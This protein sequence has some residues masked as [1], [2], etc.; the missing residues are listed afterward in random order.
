MNIDSVKVLYDNH[1]TFLNVKSI[2]KRV[3][4]LMGYTP[5]LEVHPDMYV[6][7]FELM[8]NKMLSSGLAISKSDLLSKL[9]SIVGIMTRM[10]KDPDELR[11]KILELKTDQTKQLPDVQ[12]KHDARSWSDILNIL[13]NI[14][15][16]SLNQFAKILAVCYKHG[17]VLRLGEIFNTT[18]ST[19]GRP[20]SASNFLDL[21]NKEWTINEHKAA[22]RVGQR[23]FPV[24]QAFVDELKK[25]ITFPDYLLI[26]K[27][28]YTAYATPLLGMIGINDFTVNEARNSYEEWNWKQSGRTLKEKRFWSEKV[29]GH[30]E[31][32]ARQFYTAHDMEANIMKSGEHPSVK[33]LEDTTGKISTSGKIR[34]KITPKKS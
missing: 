13:Q 1:K 22:D 19:T 23:K 17:Y 2:L 6:K 14:I 7:N 15:D 9:N 34:P 5:L 12:P 31:Q 16:K 8:C 18:T 26:Y 30:T 21:Q 24:T 11:S 25:Y 32:V 10:R 29:L 28:N 3:N 4:E 33:F 20:A 27:S